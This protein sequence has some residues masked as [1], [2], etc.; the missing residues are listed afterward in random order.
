MPTEASN[1]GFAY[2]KILIREISFI[3]KKPDWIAREEGC[4]DRL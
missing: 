4:V 1:S 3:L 2:F